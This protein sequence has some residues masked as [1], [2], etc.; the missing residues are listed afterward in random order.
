MTYQL[1]DPSITVRIAPNSLPASVAAW[2]RLRDGV[3]A[4]RDM[5]RV[6]DNARP[7][8]NAIIVS[9]PRR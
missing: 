8:I 4:L 7:R 1:T 3:H 5:L 2:D 9:S 6:L